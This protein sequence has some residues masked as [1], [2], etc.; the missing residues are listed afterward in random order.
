[1][2]HLAVLPC[3]ALARL[4][5]PSP[6]PPAR[7][8]GILHDLRDRQV[9]RVR[10]TMHIFRRGRVVPG[11][12]QAHGAR[13]CKPTEQR[14][15]QGLHARLGENPPQ[16]YQSADSTQ[17]V[18]AAGESSAAPEVTEVNRSVFSAGT[19]FVHQKLVMMPKMTE[20]NAMASLKQSRQQAMGVG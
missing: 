12:R 14:R 13:P 19:R 15:Q 4:V 9:E 8:T 5:K 2:F 16:D 20:A 3:A 1:M 18:I 7:D 11:V 6:T 17:V 10:R